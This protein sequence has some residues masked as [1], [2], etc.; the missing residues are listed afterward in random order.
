MYIMIYI[1]QDK[2]KGTKMFNKAAYKNAH[3]KFS[4]IVSNCYGNRDYV[5]KIACNKS[6]SVKAA[7]KRV[8]TADVAKTKAQFDACGIVF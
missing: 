1:R 3:K 6:D 8:Y 4:A 5:S 7:A 2:T